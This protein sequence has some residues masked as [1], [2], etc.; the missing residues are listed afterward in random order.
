MHSLP[1]TDRFGI[2]KMASTSSFSAPADI[3]RLPG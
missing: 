1:Q 3:V 2:E